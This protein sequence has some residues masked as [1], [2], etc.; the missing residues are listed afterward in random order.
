MFFDR[1]KRPLP[2]DFNEDSESESLIPSTPLRVTTTHADTMSPPP[3]SRLDY[4]HI[5]FWLKREWKEYKTAQEDSSQFGNARGS[6]GGTRSAK[7]ENVMMLYIEH[8][9]GTQVDGTMA[10]NIRDLAR[11]LWRDIYQSGYAPDTWGSATNEVRNNF[12]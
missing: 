6:R 12:Y 8:E 5:K 1:L 10:S 3:P 4:P 7:G 9:D 11:V 2:R